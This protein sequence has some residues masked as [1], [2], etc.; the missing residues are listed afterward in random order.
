M[1]VV[2]KKEVLEGIG[3]DVEWMRVSSRSSTRVFSPKWLLRAESNGTGWDESG[4]E[5]RAAHAALS[6]EQTRQTRRMRWLGSGR[7]AGGQGQRREV[8]RLWRAVTGGGSGERVLP[9]PLS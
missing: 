4:R 7:G 9:K 5:R 3:R 8:G 1:V 6:L 2:G